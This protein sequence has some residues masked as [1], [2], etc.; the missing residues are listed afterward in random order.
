VR[1]PDPTEFEPEFAIG[2]DDASTLVSRSSTPKPESTE[3]SDNAK[4]EKSVE[5]SGEAE[6]AADNTVNGKDNAPAKESGQPSAELPPEV[7]AK[8]RKL[9]KLE[10][11]YQG[12]RHTFHGS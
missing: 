1:G 3:A 4:G 8:L 2:D 12:M 7:R 5:K 6:G 9:N 10:S 11:R